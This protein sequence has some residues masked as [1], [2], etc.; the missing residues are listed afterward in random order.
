M[1]VQVDPIGCGCTECIIGLYKPLNR[2]T[3]D[4]IDRFINGEFSDATGMSE[5][6]FEEWLRKK[7]LL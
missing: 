1:F 3:T 6:A 4:E 5:F 7:G 2:L